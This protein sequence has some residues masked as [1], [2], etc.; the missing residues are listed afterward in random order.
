MRFTR[1]KGAQVWPIGSDAPHNGKRPEYE[2]DG[3]ADT[4]AHQSTHSRGAH[5]HTKNRENGSTR[6]E[7]TS[8]ENR[9]Y[10]RTESQLNTR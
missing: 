1:E 8:L 3:Q 10:G 2:P 9:W 4:A 7:L 5:K 6:P